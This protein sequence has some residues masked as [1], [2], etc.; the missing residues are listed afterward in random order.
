MHAKSTVHGKYLQ[1]ICLFFKNC[2]LYGG[3]CRG[4]PESLK[5]SGG[6]ISSNTFYI[7]A[8]VTYKPSNFYLTP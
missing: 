2:D 3:I 7:R 5:Q 4:S 1:M 8:I 6:N